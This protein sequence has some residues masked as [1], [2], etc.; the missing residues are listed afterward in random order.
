M[1]WTYPGLIP[2]HPTSFVLLLKSQTMGE[3]EPWASEK[4]FIIDSFCKVNFFLFISWI[5]FRLWWPRNCGQANCL[6]NGA[7]SWQKPTRRYADRSCLAPWY[8]LGFHV[9]TSSEKHFPRQPVSCSGVLSA[10]LCV[11]SSYR[12][13]ANNFISQTLW[14]LESL[15]VKI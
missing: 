9:Q 10:L 4:D 7:L 14:N 11:D 8:G 1:R 13:A 6:L 2:N 12:L 5:K 3:L 15:D